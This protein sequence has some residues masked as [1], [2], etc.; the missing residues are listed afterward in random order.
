M[1]ASRRRKRLRDATHPGTEAVGAA[2]R[3]GG[4]RLR[5]QATQ[6]AKAQVR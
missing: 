1:T 4:D 5:G 3:A 6:G 2:R